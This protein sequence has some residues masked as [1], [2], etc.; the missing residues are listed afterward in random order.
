M[1]TRPLGRT[2]LNVPVLAFGASPLGGVFGPVPEDACMR[3]VHRALELGVCYFDTSPFYGATRSERMLGRALR[4]VPRDR[5]L[6]STKVGRYGEHDFDFR[7]ERVASS[8]AESQERL[9]VDRFDIVFCHDIEFGDPDQITGE[10]LPALGDARAAGITAATGVS[11]YPLP[12]LRAAVARGEP[13]V[14]LSYC[15][16]ALF[17]TSLRDDA[18]FFAERGVGLINASPLG[19]GL[20]TR[21]GPPA[22]HPASERLRDVCRRAG[23]LCRRAGLDLADQ[24]LAFALEG[25]AATT[26][27]G[28]ASPEVLERN[29]ARTQSPPDVL[30]EVR[31]LFDTLPEADR[32]WRSGRLGH[33]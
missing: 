15:H 28:M 23:E 30:D 18:E 4:H 20:L 5:Y 13:D 22:W 31:S 12:V 17:N 29:A 16:Y 32:G 2:G 9:G 10:T 14:V 27:I 8:L 26:L 25:P 3:A 21:A 1:Q 7:G 11:G 19:M 24:A 6:L 33:E